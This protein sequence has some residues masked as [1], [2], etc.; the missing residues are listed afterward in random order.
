MNDVLGV[1]PSVYP[2]M[3]M[4]TYTDD[5]S[6]HATSAY[7][8]EDTTGRAVP[9]TSA[10]DAPSSAYSPMDTAIDCASPVDAVAAPTP[11][12][13]TTSTALVGSWHVS[14]RKIF[15]SASRRRA[16]RP[17]TLLGTR[18]SVGTINLLGRKDKKS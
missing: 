7:D 15:F 5:G 1:P 16:P 9:T 12:T 11:L 13:L 14:Q 17:P 3:D 2:A 6:G 18:W 10:L 4:A 8:V